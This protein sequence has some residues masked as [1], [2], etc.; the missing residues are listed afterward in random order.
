MSKVKLGGGTLLSPVPA[1]MVT[2]RDENGKDNIITIAWTGIVSSHPPKAYISVRPERYSYGIIKETGVFA[3]NLTTS[4]LSRAADLCGVKTGK[5]VDKFAACGLEKYEVED[6]PVPL[7]AESPLS[8]CCR[9]SDVVPLGSHDMFIA[10]IVSVY[11]NEELF[12]K[13][14]KLC[15]YRAPLAAYSHGEYFELGKKLGDF[16]FSVRKKKRSK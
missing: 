6:F 14:G 16:G 15:L 9:V 12:D 4:S 13:N 3:I 5:K 7:I 11:A 1:V 8:L 2:T 10:D